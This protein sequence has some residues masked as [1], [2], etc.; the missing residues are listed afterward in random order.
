MTRTEGTTPLKRASCFVY[1]R[2]LPE[3]DFIAFTLR[4]PPVNERAGAVENLSARR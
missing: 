3:S 4:K 2:R 1:T